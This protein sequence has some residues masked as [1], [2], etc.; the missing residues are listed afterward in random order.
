VKACDFVG[1]ER[2]RT[3]THETPSIRQVFVK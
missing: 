2:S 1:C 3:K